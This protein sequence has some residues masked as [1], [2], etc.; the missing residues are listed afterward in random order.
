M[1][2]SASVMCNCYRDGKAL[3]CPF[4][5]DW[6]E[7]D[8]DGFLNMKPAYDSDSN[9]HVLYEWTQ[10]CCEHK[11]SNEAYEHIVNWSRYRSFQLALE[12]V[13]WHHFPVLKSQLPNVNGGKTPSDA[14][15]IALKE[16]Q[17]F[18]ALGEIGQK[19]VLVDT[20]INSAL[21]EYIPA[22][23]GVFMHS[24][25]TCI[26]AG[27]N[28][29]EFFA[30]NS[31]TGEVLFQ[32][33]RFRQFDKNGRKLSEKSNVVVWEDLDTGAIFESGIVLSGSPI[34]WNNGQY[35]NSQ[36]QFRFRYPVE[37][38][39]E[40]RPRLATDFEDIVNPLRILFA[41]SVRTGNPV[42]WC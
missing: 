2:L 18:A 27:L 22:Y 17:Q 20:A 6:L 24:G 36:N 29:R 5:L 19:T 25:S 34:P 3:L 8:D 35:Q 37:F 41:A 23:E 1:G 30:S 4:P 21:Y 11:N 7:I 38:H 32:S 15:E 9:W 39:V 33:S 16:L 28:E 26:D 42:R 40:R 14:S 13:G 12:F 10:K 31:M